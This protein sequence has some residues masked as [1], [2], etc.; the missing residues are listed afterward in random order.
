[1]KARYRISNIGVKLGF[2]VATLL[3]VLCGGYLIFEVGRLQANYSIV[4]AFLEKEALYGVIQ[5]LEDE[6]AAFERQLILLETERTLNQ[7][8]YTLVEADLEELRRKIQEQWEEIAF[9]RGILSPDGGQHGLRVKDLKLT[10]GNEDR[11][12]NVRL[13]LM[14]GMHDRHVVGEVDLSLAGAQDGAAMTYKFKELLPV[15]GNS[16]WLFAFKYFQD[17]DRELV[18]PKGFKPEKVNIQ[19]ISKTK[20]VASV[21]ESFDWFAGAG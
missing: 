7:E 2:R 13:V 1:M 18:L 10:K 16:K 3:V 9:Y 12:Y 8:A 21:K 6:V 5:E 15:D 19:V 14:L 20:S 11:H 4:D 17:F